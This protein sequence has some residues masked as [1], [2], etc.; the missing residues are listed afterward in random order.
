M[1]E[2]IGIINYADYKIANEEQKLLKTI[3]SLHNM[4]VDKYN[5]KEFKDMFKKACNSG[6]FSASRK[7]QDLISVSQKRTEE[8]KKISMK[9][10]ASID[11]KINEFEAKI[12]TIDIEKNPNAE[13][14]I[15]NIKEKIN[16]LNKLKDQHAENIKNF[17]S[18]KRD[19]KELALQVGIASEKTLKNACKYMEQEMEDVKESVDVYLETIKS[20]TEG[21]DTK[22]ILDDILE[23]MKGDKNR[24]GWLVSYKKIE[25]CSKRNID[26]KK[27][28]PAIN[29]AIKA[30]DSIYKEITQVLPNQKEFDPNFAKNIESE[31]NGKIK[32]M[33]E[34]KYK[35][36]LTK[37]KLNVGI[38]KKLQSLVSM[39]L[40][41]TILN[42]LLLSS[43]KNTQ[44]V[45]KKVNAIDVNEMNKYIKKLGEKEYND[46][47]SNDKN[48]KHRNMGFWSSVGELL[49]KIIEGIFNVLITLVI[50]V[51]FLISAV[52]TF[53][54]DLF[55][56]S[57]F[58]L[59]KLMWFCAKI[60]IKMIWA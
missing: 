28:K 9:A 46:D 15:K 14:D 58:G 22:K 19:M 34:N 52:F 18:Q 4:R 20:G 13:E 21:V 50:I 53:F 8:Y 33:M 24:K 30:G 60:K 29:E 5:S 59:T 3:T 54:Y 12:N 6:F 39:A 7:I 26:E 38:D 45:I 43:I 32:P 11:K 37:H 51:V 47:E 31:M 55:T 49:R 25:T 2:K 56:W 1:V 44:L 42:N 27:L 48:I 17:K 35:A 23:T 16:E 40:N 57:G 41:N 36:I 10:N